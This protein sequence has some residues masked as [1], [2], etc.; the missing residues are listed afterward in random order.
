ME[1]PIRVQPGLWP[2]LLLFGVVPGAATV[3]L[4]GERLTARFGFFR[5]EAWLDN[6]VG[7]D[8]TGPYRWWRAV[9][10]RRTLGTRDLSFGGS[11]HGA[12]CLHFREP[13]LVGRFSVGDLFL[14]VDDLVGLGAALI[15]HGV[16]GQDLRN[17]R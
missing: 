10:V 5:A 7:W 12:V 4:D 6:I 11:A 8:I 17:Q 13:V 15:A 16:P 14:T 1:F 2:I 3:R 9:G